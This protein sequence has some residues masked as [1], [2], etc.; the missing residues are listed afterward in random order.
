[1][2]DSGFIHFLSL[3][4]LYSRV[5]GHCDIYQECCL[6]VLLCVYNIL[7]FVFNHVVRLN[8]YTPEYFDFLRLYHWFSSMSVPCSASSYLRPPCVADAVITFLQ[9]GFFLILSFLLSS[10]N[11]SRRSLDVY[12]TA[13][14]GVVLVRI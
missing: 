6:V 12:R 5:S 13:T 1:M 3:L 8:T 11:L 9:C 14:H 10:P 2:P 4:L 7:S